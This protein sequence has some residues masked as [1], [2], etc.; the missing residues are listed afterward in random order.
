[1]ISKEN[2]CCKIYV[3][4]YYVTSAMFVTDKPVKRTSAVK[5]TLLC[6]TSPQQCLLQTLYDVGYVC[7]SVLK[8][9]LNMG[10]F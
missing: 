7:F 3:A 5:F 1:M 2:Q 8:I 4:L 9:Y 10:E 6:I